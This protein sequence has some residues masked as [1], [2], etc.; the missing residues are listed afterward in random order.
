ME[1]IHIQSFRPL[2]FTTIR[3]LVTI[4]VLNLLYQVTIRRYRRFTAFAKLP[5]LPLIGPVGW[6]IGNLDVYYYTM[7]HLG[8]EEGKRAN[9]IILFKSFI[10]YNKSSFFIIVCRNCTN[11]QWTACN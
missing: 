4:F 7:R 6:L 10:V 3:I 9:D 5:R 11:S 1:H 2:I 8:V